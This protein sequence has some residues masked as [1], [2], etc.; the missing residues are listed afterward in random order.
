M[1][2]GIWLLGCLYREVETQGDETEFL[3]RL[4]GVYGAIISLGELMQE[5]KVFMKTTLSILSLLS[6]FLLVSMPAFAARNMGALT[7]VSFT[8]SYSTDINNIWNSL[9]PGDHSDYMYQIIPVAGGGAFVPNEAVMRMTLSILASPDQFVGDSLGY[10]D[11][12]AGNPLA[13][14]LVSAP[15][16]FPNPFRLSSGTVVRYV[17]S[18]SGAID[19][20]VY[21]MFGRRIYKTHFDADIDGVTRA[22]NGEIPFD[23]SLVGSDLSVAVY[24]YVIIHDGVVIGKGKMAIRP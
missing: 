23:R 21:D 2:I 9:N 8:T 15:L 20:H 4:I 19:F 17:L 3:N 16:N 5:M 6:V 12:N 10:F 22:G 14:E 11:P 24:F 1:S 18:S 13:V 7:P